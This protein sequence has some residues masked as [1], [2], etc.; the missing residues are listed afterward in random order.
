MSTPRI[1][2]QIGF[3]ICSYQSYNR[4]TTRLNA[5]FSPFI[6]KALQEIDGE[7]EREAILRIVDS[8]PIVI[9]KEPRPS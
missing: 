7:R 2:F 3:Q 1:T 8:M 9:L 6:E 4:R 5:V